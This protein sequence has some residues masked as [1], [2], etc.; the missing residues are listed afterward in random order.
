MATSI[1][2]VSVYRVY[3][4]CPVFLNLGKAPWNYP[5]YPDLNLVTGSSPKR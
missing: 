3:N 1:E 2:T 4:F 5:E